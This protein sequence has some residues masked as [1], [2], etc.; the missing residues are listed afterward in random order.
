MRM[1]P[2]G[3]RHGEEGALAG[4]GRGKTAEVEVLGAVE[5]EVC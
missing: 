5:G 1:A 3:T 2:G 4:P